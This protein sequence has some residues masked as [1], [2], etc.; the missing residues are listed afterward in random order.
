MVEKKFV[1]LQ[2]GVVVEIH[3]EAGRWKYLVAGGEEFGE[4][5]ATLVPPEGAE[6]WTVR[7][8]NPDPQTRDFTISDMAQGRCL[9]YE[10]ATALAMGFMAS[11]YDEFEY[12]DG[13]P[14][15][16]VSNDETGV[17]V[18]E[19]LPQSNAR[20]TLSVAS[21]GGGIWE[22]TCYTWYWDEEHR[23]FMM[24]PLTFALGTGRCWERDE[25]LR[26]GLHWLVNASII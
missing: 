6:G 12:F 21:N 15:S 13:K 7:A 19:A 9:D 1:E 23:Y 26:K 11:R 4:W 8:R 20:R 14:Y 10:A 25:A 16:F 18:A 22:A 24:A 2:N 17:L 5:D 3:I